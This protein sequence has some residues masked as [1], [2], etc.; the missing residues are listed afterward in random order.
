MWTAATGSGF[1]GKPR[2]VLVVQGDAYAD[3]PNVV[4]ALLTTAM[5]DEQGVRPRIEPDD[6]NGLEHGSLV[7]VDLLVT[8]PQRKFGSRI[9]RLSARDQAQVDRAILIY[10]GFGGSE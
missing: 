8:I 3:A 7:Q 9:G 6:G 2:P 10:L 5:H 1:G 4:V